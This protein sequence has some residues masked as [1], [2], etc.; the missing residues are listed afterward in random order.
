[1]PY[2]HELSAR[3]GKIWLEACDAAVVAG[4]ALHE[5]EAA[6]IYVNAFIVPP[7]F[8]IT[9]PRAA[10]EAFLMDYFRKAGVV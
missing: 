2:D 1:M 6:R 5:V 4:Y 8:G 10:L 7:V 9:A 3:L